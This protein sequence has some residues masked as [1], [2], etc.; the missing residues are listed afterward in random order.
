MKTA[1]IAIFAVAAFASFFGPVT[2]ALIV[3]GKSENPDSKGPSPIAVILFACGLAALIAI[4]AIPY[5]FA[6]SRDFVRQRKFA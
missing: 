3:A 5:V 6:M 4:C 2:W 1:L